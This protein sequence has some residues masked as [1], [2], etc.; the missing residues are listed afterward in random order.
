MEHE[1]LV[2]AYRGLLGVE[3]E[4][5][6]DLVAMISSFKKEPVS[7]KKQQ[8]NESV[9]RSLSIESLSHAE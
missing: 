4:K 2:D 1:A 5:R 9:S 8:S 6:L 7:C 3:A